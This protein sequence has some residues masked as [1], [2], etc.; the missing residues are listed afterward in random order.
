MDILEFGVPVQGEV[1][2]ESLLYQQLSAAVI[3]SDIRT[4]SECSPGR[5]FLERVLLSFLP[6]IEIF[7]REEICFHNIFQFTS[8]LG[9][10]LI[11]LLDD[12]AEV[13]R[14]KGDVSSEYL[15]ISLSGAST[16]FQNI[17]TAKK[18]NFCEHFD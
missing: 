13:P 17:Q 15:F 18:D 9:P 11:V 6:S 5:A 10:I 8:M 4:A 14:H 12:L 3:D 7:V 2:C 16:C 1:Y